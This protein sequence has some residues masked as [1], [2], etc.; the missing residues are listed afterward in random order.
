MTTTKTY[1]SWLGRGITL[2][3]LAVALVLLAVVIY[4]VDQRPRTHDAHLFA[5]TAG[6]APEVSGRLVAIHVVNNQLVRRGDVLAEIDPEPF[7]LRLQQARAKVAALKA[8]IDLTGRQ[9]NAQTSGAAPLT[10][11]A[12][13]SGTA[14]ANPSVPIVAAGGVVGTAS[15]VGSPAPGTLVSLFGKA[16]ADS[17]S[18][19][20][21]L[22]L[23]D[24]LK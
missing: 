15:Y 12:T 18:Q 13:V 24:R 17:V 22:P 14:P 16:L 2:I 20:Q 23:P 4:V 6:I 9:V 10:G 7:Q 5:Y 8:D 21:S 3:A 11:S 19:A 1:P